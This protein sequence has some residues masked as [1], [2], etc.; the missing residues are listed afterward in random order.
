M[1]I[2][3]EEIKLPDIF[4]LFLYGTIRYHTVPYFWPYAKKKSALQFWVS[5]GL[6]EVLLALRGRVYLANLTHWLI[7]TQVTSKS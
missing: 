6:S 5:R 3:S 1:V 2:F 7:S 4:L